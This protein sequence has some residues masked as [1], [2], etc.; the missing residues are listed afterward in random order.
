MEHLRKDHSRQLREQE[1]KNKESMES[2]RKELNQKNSTEI[3]TLRKELEVLNLKVKEKD[4]ELINKAKKGDS[5]KGAQGGG[6]SL[7]KEAV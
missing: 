4:Q 7:R 5:E 3:D 2:L 1:Q 6:Q